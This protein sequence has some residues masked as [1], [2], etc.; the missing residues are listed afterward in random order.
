M[1]AAE[2][3]WFARAQQDVYGSLYD[4]CRKQQPIPGSSPLTRL[5]PVLDTSNPRLLRMNGRL[6]SAHHLHDGIRKPIILPEKH[7]VTALRIAHED[8]IHNHTAGVN[9][10][11]SSLNTEFWIVHGPAAVKRHRSNCTACKKLWSKPTKQQMAPL[12]DFRTQKP[13][14]AFS[15]VGVDYAGPFYTKQGRGRSRAKRYLCLFTCLQ[16]RAV[17]LEMTSRSEA[18][19]TGD[20]SQCLCRWMQHRS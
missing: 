19:S 2:E 8:A 5:Q 9:Q 20:R 18:R 12:P 4:A 15:R 16:C 1:N 7:A 6:S 10:I 3:V 13:L 17:H 14:R 11:L